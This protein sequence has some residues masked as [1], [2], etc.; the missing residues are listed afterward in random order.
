MHEVKGVHMVKQMDRVSKL[1]QCKER[2][3]LILSAVQQAG[4]SNLVEVLL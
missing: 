3:P 4:T 1:E 2:A